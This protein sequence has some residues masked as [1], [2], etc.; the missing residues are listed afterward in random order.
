MLN[1]SGIKQLS[2]VPKENKGKCTK[3]IKYKIQSTNVRGLLGLTWG[4]SREGRNE[5][6]SLGG[7]VL[8]SRPT[9]HCLHVHHVH[10][11]AKNLSQET[12]LHYC[13]GGLTSAQL[14][15]ATNNMP[16]SECL[17][18]TQL[19]EEPDLLDIFSPGSGAQLPYF[20]RKEGGRLK[21]LFFT[22][23]FWD[24]P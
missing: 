14:K 7:P 13:N 18:C 24:T 15:H 17:K 20:S 23:S 22:A 4:G 9:V 19:L 1:S 2:C 5:T 10:Y 16:V 3:S 6:C 8:R 12:A 21:F 11:Y